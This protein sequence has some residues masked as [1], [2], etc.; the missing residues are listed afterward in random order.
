MSYLGYMLFLSMSASPR[1]YSNVFCG[2]SDHVIMQAFGAC[3][4]ILSFSFFAF[5]CYAAYQAPKWSGKPRP[6]RS[7]TS[8]HHGKH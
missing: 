7:E 6:L 3:V 5:A 8:T 1:K 4:I 2:S